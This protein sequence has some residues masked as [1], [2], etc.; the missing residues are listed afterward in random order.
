MRTLTSCFQRAEKVLEKFREDEY[1]QKRMRGLHINCRI[2]YL[3]K[4]YP[5]V[6]TFNNLERNWFLYQTN[7]II[8]LNICPFYDFSERYRKQYCQPVYIQDDLPE[9]LL[10]MDSSGMCYSLKKLECNCDLA[11]GCKKRQLLT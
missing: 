9:L 6:K 3:L 8:D 7:Q 1:F 11:K 10:K 5:K 2:K 4:E